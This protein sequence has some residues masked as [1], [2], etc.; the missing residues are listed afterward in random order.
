MGVIRNLFLRLHRF[1]GIRGGGQCGGIFIYLGTARR[2]ARPAH[3]CVAGWGY[4]E[5]VWREKEGAFLRES[6]RGDISQTA[7]HFS[8]VRLLFTSS[9]WSTLSSVQRR[10]LPFL[11]LAVGHTV[12]SINCK[13]IL[14]LHL[15]LLTFFICSNGGQ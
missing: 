3:G 14:N 10:T 4:R 9:V 15:S 1:I 12:I 6:A 8:N 5:I 2:G 11:G 7:Q 13:L